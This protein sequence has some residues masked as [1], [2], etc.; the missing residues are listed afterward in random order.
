MRAAEGCKADL[1]IGESLLRICWTVP[2]E[3]PSATINAQSEEPL[4]VCA[5]LSK[6]N[7]QNP[8]LLRRIAPIETGWKDPP[9]NLGQEEIKGELIISA[10]NASPKIIRIKILPFEKALDG[11]VILVIDK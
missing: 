6:S 9:R 1:K 7:S 3:R 5:V 10:K 11:K 8:T 4:D 2:E